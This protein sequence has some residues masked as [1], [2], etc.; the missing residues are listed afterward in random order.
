MVFH[1]SNVIYRLSESHAS[2]MA[3]YRFMDNEKVSISD[4]IGKVVSPTL[5]ASSGRDVLIISDS[6]EV[7]MD[8]RE[9]RITDWEDLGV[10][11]NNETPGFHIHASMALDADSGHGLGLS[12]LILWNRIPSSASKEEK[13]ASKL[14]RSWEE[15]E[16]YKWWLGV[17][18]SLELVS[19]ARSK[20]FIFDQGANFSSIWR[21]IDQVDAHFLIRGSHSWKTAHE[22]KKLFEYIPTFEL[23]GEY[24]LAIRKLNRFNYSRNK[25]QRRKARTAKIAI[26]YGPVTIKPAIRRRSRKSKEVDLFFVDAKELDKSV[27]AEEKPIQWTLLTTHKL[28]N[29]DDARRMIKWY[30][31]RWMIEQL[32]RIIKRKGFDIESTELTHTQAIF[33]QSILTLEAGFRVLQLLLAREQDPRNAPTIG[34]SFTL[35]QQKCLRA[36]N[37][38]LEGKTNK[39]KNPFPKNQLAFASWVIARLGGWKGYNSQAPPGPITFK[40]GLDRFQQIFQGWII[41]SDGGDMYNT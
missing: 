25:P 21:A 2:M 32:F 1:Q 26:R 22:G 35:Q 36:L 6:S 18:K 24:S 12:D 20:T 38:K 31:K 4:L 28:E 40:R 3:N 27:P 23:A 33:K 41:F 39:L 11:S 30:E 15:K 5:E 19:Q 8:L 10:L 7:S 29:L 13:A 16:S 14:E 17:E 37:K 9:D 34:N